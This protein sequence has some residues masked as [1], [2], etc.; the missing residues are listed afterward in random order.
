MKSVATLG[1]TPIE[2]AV[3]ACAVDPDG[4]ITMG[5]DGASLSLTTAGDEGAGADITDVYCILSELEMPDSV[6]NRIDTT[7]ALDGRQS[8]EWNDLAAS[9]GYHPDDG[10]NLIIE[11]RID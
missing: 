3:S 1:T 8:G 9:W 7:R 4:F 11:P 2:D 10:L 5:D 6:M